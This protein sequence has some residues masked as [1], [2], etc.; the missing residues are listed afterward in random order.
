MLPAMDPAEALSGEPR[1]PGAHAASAPSAAQ[2]LRD[3]KP[4]DSNPETGSYDW[5]MQTL[6]SWGRAFTRE[7]EERFGKQP[8]EEDDEPQDDAS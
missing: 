2:W 7:D 1:T 6:L 5:W 4:H 3:P 8:G